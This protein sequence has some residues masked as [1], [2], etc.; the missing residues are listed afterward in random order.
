M[1]S[2]QRVLIGTNRPCI[3]QLFSMGGGEEAQRRGA[4]P[5]GGGRARELVR[6]VRNI[7]ADVGGAR[8][9]RGRVRRA[10]ARG[11]RP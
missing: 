2:L 8:G 1:L 5:A 10:A 9:R 11:G 4:A 7:G 6:Q 3:C